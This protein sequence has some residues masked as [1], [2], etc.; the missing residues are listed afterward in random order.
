MSTLSQFLTT[1]SLRLLDRQIFN[2]SGTWTR[3][4]AGAGNVA[5]GNNKM[6]RAYVLGAGGGGSGGD[7]SANTAGTGGCGGGFTVA[8][9]SITLVSATEAVVVGAGGTGGAAG[10][11]GGSGGDSSFGAL[12]YAGGGRRQFSQ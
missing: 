12:A 2:A 4:A 3:P 8:E 10:L 6:V 11:V 1:G 9:Y 5:A 7:S